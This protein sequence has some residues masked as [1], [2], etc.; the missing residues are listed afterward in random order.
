M[1]ENQRKVFTDESLAAFVDEIKTYTESAVSGKADSDH[2]HDD[3]YDTKGTAQEKADAVQTNLDSLSAEVDECISGL[4]ISGKTITYTKNNGD[5]G[6]ITTQDTDTKVTNTWNPNVKAYI[7]GTTSYDTSTGTQ[8]F[9]RTIYIDK[10]P[11]KLVATTF[12][13]TL[14]GTADYANYAYQAEA[15]DNGDIISAK[16]ETKSNASAKLTEA[17]TY[18]DSAAAKVKNDLLNGAGAAYDTLKE[19]GELIDDNTDAIELLNDVAAGKADATH[20]HTISEITNLQT[21]LNGKANS[22]HGTHVS[23]SSTAPVMDGTASVGSASTVA[24]SDHKHPVDTS[25]ASQADLDALEEVVGTKVD[26]VSGKGLS[27]NDY[28][29]TEKNKLAGIAS[30]AEVNQNAFSNVTVGST[31][32]AADG[33]QDTLTIASGGNI[34]ITPDASAD[35]VTFTVADGTTGAKGVVQLTNSTSSTSTTTAATPSSVKSAYDL[36]NTAKTTADS[37]QAAITGAATTIT[38][39]NLTAS[40]ALVSNA[41]GKVAV[42]SVTSTQ[43]GYLS[44]VTSAIQTQ[45]NGKLSTSGTAAKATADAS[46]N[47]I[48]STYATKTELN[49]RHKEITQA[50]YNALSTTEKNNGTVYMITDAV[51]EFNA[52]QVAYN[53]SSSGLS[54]VDVQGA[55]DELDTNRITVQ[56][57]T[58]IHSVNGLILPI[59]NVPSG[60]PVTKLHM[61]WHDT[62]GWCLVVY[63]YYNGQI[64]QGIIK[65]TD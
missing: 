55:I 4:S 41:S 24:R 37:K 23:Y 42:S 56:E 53:N 60:L 45:L 14:K 64:C 35:K 3:L 39:S 18:A 19:L 21:T 25:R 31:T 44:G 1:A 61:T 47:T 54:A 36:A 17:K 33:K 22:S 8:V 59:S 34:T 49:N 12:L 15:D 63:Y 43:L 58:G 32:I 10:E 38:G 20:S 62:Y 30:G 28:T 5:T 13:G 51:D 57:G 29:T 11:G 48:T 50:A 7:T 46:G 27:T 6:T 40:R 52:G 65:L 26:K 2:K 9:D 16:Y